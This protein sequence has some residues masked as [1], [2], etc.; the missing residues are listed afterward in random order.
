MQK[1]WMPVDLNNLGFDW[2]SANLSKYA[3][4]RYFVPR[5]VYEVLSD[6]TN[7]PKMPFASIVNPIT[8]AFRVSVIAL[9]PRVQ[10]YNV[11]GGATMLMGETGPGGFKYLRQAMDWV[12]NP[13][14]IPEEMAGLRRTLGAQRQIM[15]EFDES[16][17]L[18]ERQKKAAAM[19]NYAGGKTLGRL[20]QEVRNSK[21]LGMVNKAADKMFDLNAFMDDTYRAMGYMHGYDKALTKG[22]SREVAEK[23][24]L[25]LA[26]KVMMDWGGLTPV[27]RTLMK[28]IFPFYSFMNHAIRYVARY[29][30]D[31]PLRAAIVGAF[32]R[33]QQDDLDGLLPDRFL[34]SFFFGGTD[35][36]GNRNALNLTP[37]NPFGDV[38]NMMTLAGFL[39]ATNP[40]IATALE[41]VGLDRGQAEL[42]P[43]L[44]YNAETGRLEGVRSNPLINFAQN[45][46]PQSSILL[47]MFGAKTDL[48]DQIARDPNAALRTLASTGGLPILWRQWNVP[49]EQFKSEMARQESQDTVL[50]NALKSGNWDEAARYP[51]LAGVQQQV[52]ALPQEVLSNFTTPE[53]QAL[54]AQIEA[55]LAGQQGAWQPP[56]GLN[57]LMDAA[58]TPSNPLP[59]QASLGGI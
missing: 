29:P 41:S 26:R 50:N 35:N 33:A 30:I 14:M 3:Q 46:I 58:L 48:A 31:H 10:L 55:L 32:G 44:R 42:Y 1:Q 4:E 49:Q 5:A 8:K 40:L 19:A 12:R 24:G 39:S 15:R 59:K 36:Q 17:P 28:S 34:G 23:A 16:L 38:A 56:D 6:M 37:F 7:R 43:S 25:E 11:L 47:T 45:T 9:S 13:E 54:R 51:G 2:R 18:I 22:M 21:A 27:E 53:Q 20:W 57:E 52:A